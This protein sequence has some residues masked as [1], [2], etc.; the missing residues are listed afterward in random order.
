MEKRFSFHQVAEPREWKYGDAAR[1]ISRGEAAW[2][3]ATQKENRFLALSFSILIQPC[4]KPDVK[5]T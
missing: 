4:L 5:V 2:V 1:H 3:T